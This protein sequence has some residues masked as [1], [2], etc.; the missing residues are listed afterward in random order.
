[1]KERLI[2]K[3]QSG[4]VNAFTEL[5]E[6]HKIALYKVAKSYL[7]HE[8]DVAD[9][10]QDTVLSAWE[11]LRDL[12]ELSYFKTWLTRICINRCNDI[13]RRQKR[14]QP[15]EYSEEVAV[16]PENDRDFYELLEE[17]PE[18]YRM[19]FLLYYGQGFRTKEIAELLD[20][21]ENTVKSRLARGRQRLKETLTLEM[22]RGSI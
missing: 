11:H 2:Q 10:M 7:K 21:N 20:L 5:M 22:G 14:V 9:A 15:S 1:M 8:D 3:A 13:L 4:D 12:R 17:L 6:Q 18:E 16:A 19:I